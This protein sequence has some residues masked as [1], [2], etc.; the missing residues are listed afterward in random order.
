MNEITLS[1]PNISCGHCVMTIKRES[2]FLDGV[3]FV[4]GDIEARTATFQVSSDKAVGSLKEMLVDIG[5][6]ADS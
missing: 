1:I 3:E 6:P 4:S 5:Y 2:G